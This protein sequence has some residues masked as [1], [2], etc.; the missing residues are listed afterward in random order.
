VKI[1]VVLRDKTFSCNCKCVIG[2][3]KVKYFMWDWCISHDM[4]FVL[5]TQCKKHCATMW[6][7]LQK[8]NTSCKA[9]KKCWICDR[10]KLYSTVFILSGYLFTVLYLWYQLKCIWSF[11]VSDLKTLTLWWNCPIS[12]SRPWLI[13]ICFNKTWYSSGR[14]K[15]IL[16][17]P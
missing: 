7:Q 1:G 15:S 9:F 10:F 3:F 17:F 11:L 6:K 16:C 5:A 4:T 14:K 12:H 13:I 2:I 8:Q